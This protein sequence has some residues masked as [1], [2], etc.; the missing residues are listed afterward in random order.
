MK[1]THLKARQLEIAIS[2]YSP[3]YHDLAKRLSHYLY[4]FSFL[5]FSY[6]TYNYKMEHGKVSRDFVTMSQWCDGWSQMVKSQVTVT[7]CHMTRLTWG[8]W[9][10]KRIAIVVKCISSR[11]LSENSIEFSLSNSEQRDSWLNSGHWTLDADTARGSRPA[12]CVRENS[13]SRTRRV[14]SNH[15]VFGR[16]T[17]SSFW[18]CYVWKFRGFLCLTFFVVLLLCNSNKIF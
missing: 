9:E 11:G 13:W 7:V 8:P 3:A 15:L 16:S 14:G 2:F 12:Y 10:S 18:P 17:V 1:I 5:F 4:F 6:W